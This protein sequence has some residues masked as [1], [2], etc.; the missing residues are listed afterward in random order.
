[1]QALR[2]GIQLRSCILKAPVKS[3]RFTFISLLL[4]LPLNPAIIT[5]WKYAF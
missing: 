2:A 3:D 5:D 4:L 1:L